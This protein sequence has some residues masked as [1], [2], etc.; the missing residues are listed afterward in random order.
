M[1]L[2][3]VFTWIL[4]LELFAYSYVINTRAHIYGSLHYMPDICAPRRACVNIRHSLN[5]IFYH[6]HEKRHSLLA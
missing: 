6:A 2:L 4:V 3:M 1:L 5:I